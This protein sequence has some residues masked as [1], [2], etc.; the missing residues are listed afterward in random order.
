MGRLMAIDIGKKRTGLAVT[1]PL[2][3]IANGLDTIPTHEI[4]P[5]LQKYFQKE[6]V[7]KVIVGYP[8]QMNNIPSEAVRYVNEFRKKFEKSF[9]SMEMVFID[10]RFTSKMAFQSLI[11]GGLSK[12]QRRDKALIDKVSA[13]II[14][15]SYME[16]KDNNITNFS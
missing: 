16:M 3:L 15:Q 1:D 4:I 13:T 6:Q 9:P 12:K 11:D 10:E 7:D 5:Y 2:Q 8:K 14:L